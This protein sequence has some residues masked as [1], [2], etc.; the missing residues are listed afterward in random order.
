M[1]WEKYGIDISKIKGKSGKMTC[2][3]CSHDRKNKTDQCLSVNKEEGLFNCH[4]CGFSGT[5]KEKFEKRE[6]ILPIPRLEKLGKKALS[7]F[8]NDRKISNYTLLKHGVT[9]GIEWMPQFGTETAVICLNY[10]RG[11][12][13]VNIK[14]RGAKKAF[15]M[16][17]DAELIFYNLNSI[18]NE[19]EVI[20]CEGEIDCLTFSECG[21]YNSVSVP[22]GASAGNQRLEYLDNCWEYFENK[23]KIIL[24]VDGDDPGISLRNEL[25][26]RLGKE[27]CWIVTYPDGC[28]DAN[29]VL[30]KHGKEAVKELV[31]NAKQWPLEGIS[32]VE[33]FF[34]E[35]NQWYHNGYPKSSRAGIEGLDQM[36]SFG[37]GKL[38]IVTGIPGHGKDEFLNLIINGLAVNCNWRFGIA[39]FEESAQVTTTKLIEKHVGKA[40]DF[41][42]EKSDRMTKE[43][44]ESAAVFADD[45]YFFLNTDE[46][47]KG[48]DGLFS[49]FGELVRRKGISAIVINPWNCIEHN[50]PGGQSETLY[51]SEF[52]TSLVNFIKRHDLHCFLVAH[53]RKMTKT[54]DNGKYEIPTLYDIS[55]SANFFNKTHN[56]ICVYRDYETNIATIYIQK[57]KQ[58]WDGQIGWVS[59]MFDTMTRQYRYLEGSIPTIKVPDNIINYSEGNNIEL[60]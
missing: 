44:F 30:V 46:V 53:P 6:Y 26:R 54:K 28:K 4:N 48:K 58:S 40:F 1:N 47:E 27:R 31:E 49:K 41:R 23:E 16:A 43:Q 20:I 35:I 50:I 45:H 19:K 38:T 9:E 56:G 12:R 34:D 52:L 37:P 32:T 11:D 17:K 22:N 36:I 10:Y 24:A 8:E 2:P 13:L 51:T 57:V 7:F 18:E 59:Y 21:I 14:F 25:A 55:G 15:K 39:P 29:E 5:A 3:K 42:R 60:F 33:D